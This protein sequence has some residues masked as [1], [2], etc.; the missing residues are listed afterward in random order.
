MLKLVM[1]RLMVGGILLVVISTVTF[2]LVF[3]GTERVVV[4]TLGPTATDADIAAFSARIGIDRPLMVQFGSWVAGALL[5]DLGNAW[6]MPGTVV[7]ALG[8][9]LPVTLSIV[10]CAILLMALLST[11]LGVTAAVRG[12]LVDRLI[13][14]GS[15]VGF[16]MPNFWTGLLLIMFFAL[17]L[18]WLPATGYVSFGSS[19]RGWALSVAMPVAALLLSG[20]ASA[21]QQV[22]G[23]MLDAM[24]QDYVRT[25]W[26]RGVA[27]SS[28]IFR[29]ALRNAIPAAL[30]V[31]SVQFIG[32]L[33]GA[34]VIERAFAIPGLGALTVQAA[35]VGDVPILMGVVT[36]MMVVVVL[37]NILIDVLNA[38]ANP[39]VR[40]S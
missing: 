22:R 14:V 4:N 27:P 28:I 7:Q 3:S 31:L 11:V 6:T 12:G 26:A 37:V 2:F 21:S 20:V 9:T 18:G 8:R 36:M 35:I 25:L 17:F 39:K 13:Q 30:T 33:S 1:K 15:I 10:T 16:S 5:G 23:A 32:L 34:A 19:I 29:H 24:R 40:L 38:V